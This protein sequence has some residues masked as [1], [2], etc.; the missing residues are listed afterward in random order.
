[1]IKELRLN[2]LL[3]FTRLKTLPIPIPYQSQP[4]KSLAEQASISSVHDKFDTL[5]NSVTE[6][7]PCEI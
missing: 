2:P 3:K 1:M 4:E 7:L 5:T 6:G